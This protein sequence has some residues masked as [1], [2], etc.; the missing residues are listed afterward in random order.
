[1]STA[2]VR[3][4]LAVLLLVS[5]TG[6]PATAADAATTWVRPVPGALARPFRAPT[7]P[8]GAGHR[9]VDLLAAPGEPV[10]APA[11]APEAVAEPVAETADVETA[12][13]EAQA[14]VA[15]ATDAAEAETTDTTTAEAEATAADA[16]AESTDSTDS[17]EG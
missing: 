1:M 5:A 10:L 3:R 9:G 16:S 13:V 8:Y 4:A 2:S 15:E 7:G 14:S 12:A 6:L 11:A 17:T